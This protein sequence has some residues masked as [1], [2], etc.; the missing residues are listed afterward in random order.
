MITWT[1]W[2]HFS[3]SSLFRLPWARVFCLDG[4]RRREQ[5]V[6]SVIFPHCSRYPFSYFDFL[7]F[8]FLF[9]SILYILWG[10]DQFAVLNDKSVFFFNPF[11]PFVIMID[12]FFFSLWINAL[13]WTIVLRDLLCIVAWKLMHCVCYNVRNC[14]CLWWYWVRMGSWDT[15][16]CYELHMR[17][18]KKS[19]VSYSMLIQKL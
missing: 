17:S 4:G 2:F 13:F 3:I 9:I 7:W 14:F 10:F 1:A 16:Q 6:G 18:T 5:V 15:D 8:F 11:F 19:L 12:L